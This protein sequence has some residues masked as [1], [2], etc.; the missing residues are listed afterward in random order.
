MRGKLFVCPIHHA[1]SNG[2]SRNRAGRVVAA[3]ALAPNLR[4]RAAE[5]AWGDDGAG[6]WVVA[7]G[8]MDGATS[9]ASAAAPTSLEGR[10]FETRLDTRDGRTG[11]SLEETKDYSPLLPPSHAGYSG[12]R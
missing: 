8:A 9:A 1:A 12:D 3:G 2:V 7:V 10:V 4:V 5:V 6:T 11:I